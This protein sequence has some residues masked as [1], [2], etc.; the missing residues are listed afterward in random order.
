[1]SVS[2]PNFFNNISSSIGVSVKLYSESQLHLCSDLKESVQ[3][4]DSLMVESRF[5]A[6]DYSFVA[7]YLD[8]SY[9]HRS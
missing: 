8:E 1:M 5:T 2:D 6:Q 9:V 4:V 3:H 7:K